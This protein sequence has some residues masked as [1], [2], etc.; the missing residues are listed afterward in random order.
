LWLSQQFLS[1][2]GGH[3]ACGAMNKTLAD[4]W[5]GCEIHAVMRQ[6]GNT[7]VMRIARCNYRLLLLVV[8]FALPTARASA[9]MSPQMSFPTQK[10]QKQLTPEQQ[11]YQNELDE[12]Y[13][14]ANKKIPDQKPSDPWASMRSAPSASA[15]K[16]KQQ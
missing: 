12:N 14:A 11:K 2:R 13:K 6:Q 4:A 3:R 10:Q 15:P 16:T 8:A 5:P 9:Q 1:L 7:S